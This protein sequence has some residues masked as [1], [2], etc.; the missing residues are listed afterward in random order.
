MI[1]ALFCVVWIAQ[2]AIF[3]R[4]QRGMR[5]L[6]KLSPP[7]P[8]HWPRVS[9]IA[10]ARDEAGGIGP[11]LR[12]RLADDYPD[13]EIVAIDDRSTDATGEIIRA[14]AE[15]DPRLVAVR[16]DELPVGWLGKVHALQ[17]GKEAASG[18][19]LLFSD[20]D[21]H[22]EPGT[23]RRAIAHALSGGFD[24]VALI[25]E[26]GT[27]SVWVEA[28]WAVFMRM[29]GIMFDFKAI[30]DS[31][32]PKAVIGS[33]AFNLVRREAFDATEGFEW[34][35]LETTDDMSLG[36]MMKR[37]GFR[38]EGLDGR[39]SASVLIYEDLAAFY[40]GTEKNAGAVLGTPF[41]LF[42]AGT[43]VWLALEWSSLIA[44]AVG[45][46]W[47]RVLGGLTLAMVTALHVRALKTNTGRTAA[48][49]LWPIGSVLFASTLVRAT[50]LAHRRGGIMWRG[51]LYPIKDILAARR[52]TLGR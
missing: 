5:T 12:S 47:L 13:L 8:N 21:V 6:A 24:H 14:L 37:N 43:I 7:E 19:W 51:T 17:R 46:G 16:I 42:V 1:I 23:T 26:Y 25:P 38:S 34:L 52:Y 39:G 4:N 45:P 33:G 30:R 36:V 11:A 27:G 49:F 31:D 28:I 32:N 40:R 20:A 15:E 35:K 50:W 22:V 10:P 29:F 44:L 3:V 41:P 2:A 18:E 9:V 48:A